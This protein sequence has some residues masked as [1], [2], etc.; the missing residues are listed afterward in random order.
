MYEI[1]SSQV[2][3]ILNIS[4]NFQ[5]NNKFK[6]FIDSIYIYLKNFINVML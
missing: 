1:V 5:K 2:N 6:M 3:I 4:I